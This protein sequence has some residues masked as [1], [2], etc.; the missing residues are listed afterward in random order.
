MIGRNSADCLKMPFGLLHPKFQEMF[1]FGH[2]IVMF[3]QRGRR[4]NSHASK[5]GIH[6]GKRITARVRDP[7]PVGLGHVVMQSL[8][9]KSQS[10][11]RKAKPFAFSRDHVLLDEASA[12]QR[13]LAMGA[14]APSSMRAC[15]FSQFFG[16]RLIKIIAPDDGGWTV[17][18]VGNDVRFFLGVSAF[19]GQPHACTYIVQEFVMKLAYFERKIGHFF[20]KII[21]YQ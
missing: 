21:D 20:A 14:L 13:R 7:S 16:E 5:S 4:G 15:E 1:P 19:S 2:G 12:L 3:Q 10:I 17:H 18:K 8:I 6:Y 11:P 9:E